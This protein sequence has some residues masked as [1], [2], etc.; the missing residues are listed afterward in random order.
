MVAKILLNKPDATNLIRKQPSSP[1]ITKGMRIKSIPQNNLSS[2]S[3]GIL[4]TL[5]HQFSNLQ[6]GMERGQNNSKVT[7][8]KLESLMRDF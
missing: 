8:S 2:C 1:L 7:H 3:V 5:E 6:I 4:P